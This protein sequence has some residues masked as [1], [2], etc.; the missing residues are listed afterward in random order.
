MALRSADRKRSAICLRSLCP[1]NR[2]CISLASVQVKP[3]RLISFDMMENARRFFTALFTASVQFVWNG[4]PSVYF[5]GLEKE[6][7]VD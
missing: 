2:L 1:L 5:F 3:C 6:P 4:Y 7:P